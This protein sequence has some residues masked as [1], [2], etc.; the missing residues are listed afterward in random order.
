MM[1][2]VRI[3]KAFVTGMLVS[4][5]G[6]H[7][8][9]RCA[10]LTVEPCGN[11]DAVAGRTAVQILVD[12]DALDPLDNDGRDEVSCNDGYHDDCAFV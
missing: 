6:G 11:V 8:T 7:I 2:S 12:R 1:Q 9:H 10:R 5:L 3:V 4:T